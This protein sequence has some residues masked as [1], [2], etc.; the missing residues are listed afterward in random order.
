MASRAVVAHYDALSTLPRSA[1]SEALRTFCNRAKEKLVREY[2]ASGVVL[3]LGGGRGGDLGK[4]AR[5]RVRHV[6][7]VDPSRASLAAAAARAPP[8]P[9]LRLE[10]GSLTEEGGAPRGAYSAVACQF[11]LHYVPSSELG[12]AA[13][14]AHA[15][16][17]PGG[18]WFG[19]AASEAGV[20]RCGAS[21]G[22]SPMAHGAGLASELAS[23]EWGPL[24][25]SH[26]FTLRGSVEGVLEH[27][28]DEAAL[29][30]AAAASGLLPLLALPLLELQ[31]AL[32]GGEPLPP[33]RC[34]LLRA[35]SAVLRLRLPPPPLH[36][37]PW[38]LG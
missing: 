38:V 20:A 21:P 3:D 12:A 1:P 31:S 10:E 32:P 19:I 18:V 13:A 7:L 37:P 33:P 11:A 9:S 17:A 2:A 14:R 24:P 30:A 36:P 6:H 27:P 4:Y 34:S 28:V 26:Y 23:L 8:L 35:P 16:L 29:S 5:A 25:G 15:A 22:W